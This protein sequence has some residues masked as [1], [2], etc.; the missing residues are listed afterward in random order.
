[1]SVVD[2]GQPVPVAWVPCWKCALTN[3]DACTGECIG[4]WLVR[5]V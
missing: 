3:V 1:M 5:R 4:G 2:D